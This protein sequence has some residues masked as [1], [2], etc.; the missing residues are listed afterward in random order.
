ME[1]NLLSI[2]QMLRHSPRLDVTF[3]SHQCTIT[4]RETQSVVAVGLQDHGLFRLVDS[5]VSQDLAMASRQSSLSTLWHQRYGHSNVSYLAQLARDALVLGLPEIQTQQVG[6][7]DACQAGKQHRTPFKSGDS[8][9]AS[10]VLQL[11][12]VDICGPMATPFVLGSRYFLL[13]FYDFNRKMWVYF[14]AKKSEAFTIF[15]KFK[16]LVEKES[17]NSIIALRSDNEGEF[18]SN[19]F[20]SF[21]DIHGIKHQLTTPHTPQQNSVVERRNRT[22]I[23]M[24]R[25]MLNHR[26]VPKQF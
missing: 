4:D 8:W 19:E 2:S 16:P 23:E 14:L 6:V 22:I 1:L 24:A 20:S 12:H 17:G 10:Q 26:H 18:C 13:I 25:S 9:Q 3:S 11:V 15:Q 21:Y 7:C 5:G